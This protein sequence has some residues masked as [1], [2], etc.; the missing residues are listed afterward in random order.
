MQVL[1]A[2]LPGEIAAIIISFVRGAAKAVV[3]HE[4]RRAAG[5]HTAHLAAPPYK[6]HSRAIT[7]QAAMAAMDSSVERQ[8]RQMTDFIRLEAKEKANEIRMK[9][10]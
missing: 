3:W 4:W 8:I 6:R 7:A 1:K 5:V 9:A 10:S 2:A